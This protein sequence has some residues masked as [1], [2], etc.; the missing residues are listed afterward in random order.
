[1][2]EVII[3]NIHDYSYSKIICAIKEAIDKLV[4]EFAALP[5]LYVADGH[6]RTAS[7]SIVRKWRKDTNPNHTGDEEYNYFLAVLFPNE[8]LHI[9]DYNRVVKD[10]N[11]MSKDD[12]LEAISG[13]FDYEIPGGDGPYK[14]NNKHDFGMYLDDDWYKLTAKPGTYDDGDPVGCLDVAILQNNLLAPVLGIGD[15]RTD[16]RIDFVGGIRGLGELE[17]RCDED[18]HAIAFA[19]YPTSIEELM[20]IADAGEIMPPKSTWFE[21]KLAD[22]LL[23]HV[24]D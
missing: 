16:K 14:P 24:L 22:G 5:N 8:Q 23:S 2:P 10:L 6:H 9:M 4:T 7:G 18:G 3:Q 12:F 11:G 13:K 17:K 20:D 1:M 15:P 19:L 21:P